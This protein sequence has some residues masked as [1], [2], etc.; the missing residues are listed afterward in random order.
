VAQPE[1]AYSLHGMGA[2]HFAEYAAHFT[3]QELRS[4]TNYVLHTTGHRSAI[5]LGQRSL[6]AAGSNGGSSWRWH[7][8]VNERHHA[9]H[10]AACWQRQLG[11]HSQS[12]PGTHSATA[13]CTRITD[14]RSVLHVFMD[15][16]IVVFKHANLRM[17]C[18]L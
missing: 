2:C 3:S 5:V 13:Q 12:L 9:C 18:E 16:Y 14:L 11:E 17:H 6:R 15:T 7:E 1:R 10:D 4:C 8:S